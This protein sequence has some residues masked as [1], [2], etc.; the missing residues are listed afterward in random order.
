MN[1]TKGEWKVA[2]A[3]KPDNVG[4]FDYAIHTKE[5]YILAEVFEVVAENVKLPNKAN[6]LLISPAPAMYEALKDML[7]ILSEFRVEGLAQGSEY[8]NRIKIAQQIL[9]KLEE[10][11]WLE[12]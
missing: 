9:T 4:G 11:K 1:Y 8:V 2:K 6:A 5:G 12:I 3:P 7:G 10:G